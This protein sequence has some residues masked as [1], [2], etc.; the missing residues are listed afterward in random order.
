MITR[1]QA[2]LGAGTTGV[3]ILVV[4]QMF[5]DELY[6][7][8]MSVVLIAGNVGVA[9]FAHKSDSGGGLPPQNPPKS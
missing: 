5:T 4:N 7:L 2:L 6:K 8:I 3:G 1:S 9:Y